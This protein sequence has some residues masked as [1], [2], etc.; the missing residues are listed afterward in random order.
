M[1]RFLR[2]VCV[3][4]LTVLFI[5]LCPLS[6]FSF[7]L[8]LGK[9]QT[10]INQLQYKI[11]SLLAKGSVFDV[12][13]RDASSGDGAFL[14]VLGRTGGKSIGDLPSSFFVE[15]LFSSTGRFSFYGSPTDIKVKG[16][17][18]EGDYRYLDLSFS[19]LSQATQ[20]EIP[21]RAVVAATI[22][23]GTDEAVVLVGS[24]TAAR[25]KRGSEAIPAP[26]TSLKI[27]GRDKTNMNA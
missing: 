15:R 17:R 22:P 9:N 18:V 3:T 11:L 13:C 23:S 27:C 8:I 2:C 1:R 7:C 12:E 21:R 19:N 24:A 16:S 10:K 4:F 20:A 25:W 14:S 26:K 6:S 5:S